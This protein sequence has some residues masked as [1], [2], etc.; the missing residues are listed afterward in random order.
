MASFY[1][2]I[3]RHCRAYLGNKYR[4]IMDVS[5]LAQALPPHSRAMGLD[6]WSLADCG[7]ITRLWTEMS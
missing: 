1:A 7:G 4:W 6:L 3:G 2:D 5:T